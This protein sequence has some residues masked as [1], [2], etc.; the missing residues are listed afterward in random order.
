MLSR[1][2]STPEIKQ[3][4]AVLFIDELSKQLGKPIDKIKL[5]NISKNKSLIK[6]GLITR[7]NAAGLNAN[8]EII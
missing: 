4:D 1:V 2:S 7:L 5:T 3:A 8:I 6:S